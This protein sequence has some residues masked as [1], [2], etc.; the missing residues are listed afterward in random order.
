MSHA[1]RC[2]CGAIRYELSGEPNVVALCHCRD[3]QRSAGAPAVTWAMFP[4]EALSVTQGEPKSINGSGGAVRSFCPD[5]GSGL[6]YY[7]AVNLPGIVDVQTA[8]LDNPESLPPQ[9]QIQTAE[10]QGWV[11]HLDQLPEFERFPA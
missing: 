2:Y 11:A 1:G 6:F 3:C 9:V 4:A 7:N 5:C 8:T 10:R